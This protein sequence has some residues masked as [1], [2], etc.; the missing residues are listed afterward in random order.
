[1][2]EEVE[3]DPPLELA[4]EDTFPQDKKMKSEKEVVDALEILLQEAKNL[5]AQEQESRFSLEGP[6]IP[7]H[8]CC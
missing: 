7:L 3:T 1:M 5:L 8:L 2:K 6:S 4:M